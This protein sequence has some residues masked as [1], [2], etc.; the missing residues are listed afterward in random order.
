MFPYLLTWVISMAYPQIIIEGKSPTEISKFSMLKKMT[1]REP[2]VF[3]PLDVKIGYLYYGGNKYSSNLPFNSSLVTANDMPVILDST[4]YDFNI[5][6]P[7]NKRRLFFMELDMLRTNLT[8]FIFHQ[9]YIDLQMGLGLQ[10]I[11]F[12]PD[13]SLPSE[14][15]KKWLN[16]ST[17]K[18]EYFFHPKS[19]GLNLNTSLAWQLSYSHFYYVYHSMGI[20]SVSVYESSGNKK[21]ITGMGLSESFGIGA[22]I[23]FEQENADFNYTL[24]IEAKW[25][26]LYLGSVDAP[27]DL[28]PIEGLDIKSS[29]I[30]IS[31]GVQFG[32]NKTNGDIAYA[33]MMESD[34]MGA[35][36]NFKKFLDAEQRHINRKK[37]IEMLQYCE[38]QI[39]YQQ[40][41]TGIEYYL[42]AKYDK[43]IEWFD[44]AEANADQKTKE[45]LIAN[46][47]LLSSQLLDSIINNKNKLSITNSKKIAYIAKKYDPISIKYKQ[48]MA[49]LYMDKAN[50]NIKINNFSG[51]INDFQIALDYYPEIEPVIN[52]EIENI[53]NTMMED[54]YFSFKENDLLMV[55]DLLNYLVDI[56][57]SREKELDPYIIKMK[58]IIDNNQEM[59]DI[60]FNE[61]IKNE[62]HKSLPLQE[63]GVQLGMKK[64]KVEAVLGKPKYKEKNENFESWTY[65]NNKFVSTLFFR[66]NSLIKIEK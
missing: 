26:R 48:V 59:L 22:K 53:I 2:I 43:S 62:K 45:L 65:I 30:F 13:L 14:T 4:Q 37:A 28:S 25:N 63:Q 33:L 10:I 7:T 3:T 9:N 11:N 58:Q 42:S 57:P 64:E 18:G 39:V 47:Q 29:G 60:N 1:F 19:I 27:D 56:Q 15:G 5:I 36:E 16:Q 54:A 40:I 23:V 20:S 32:G 17:N 34:F 6:Q 66:D 31:Y 35:S 50:L 55:L 41:K 38:S 61:H 46:R 49:S 12:L 21:N 44:T 52:D 8:H 51:A 24:G